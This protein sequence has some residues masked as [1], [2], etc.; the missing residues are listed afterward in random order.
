M[1]CE[2]IARKY[3]GTLIRINTREAEV[4]AGHI[5]LP[6]GA[7]AALEALDARLVQGRG[8]GDD[9]ARWRGQ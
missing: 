1:V 7:L 2:D 4:P 9:A 6:L 5:S 8:S 3:G